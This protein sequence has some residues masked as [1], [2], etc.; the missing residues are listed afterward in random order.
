MLLWIPRLFSH[1]H[2][3]LWHLQKMS[4]S[5]W[6]EKERGLFLWR[7]NTFPSPCKGFLSRFWI[8][9]NTTNPLKNAYSHMNAS[10]LIDRNQKIPA[11][12]SKCRPSLSGLLNIS[13]KHISPQGVVKPF[14][15]EG[16]WKEGWFSCGC[17]NHTLSGSI[18][19]I[20][21]GKSCIS[22]IAKKTKIACGDICYQYC[23]IY[24]TFASFKSG[25]ASS[26]YS[27]CRS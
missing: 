6:K 20:S 2:D 4:V 15:G 14:K 10:I 21:C 16:K 8:N 13:E 7:A 12:S 27:K 25:P 23:V 1:S 18:S 24:S 19:G 17:R 11:M 5:V 9:A 22:I 3:R 26:K